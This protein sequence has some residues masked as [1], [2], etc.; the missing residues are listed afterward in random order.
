MEAEK[1]KAKL[2]AGKKKVELE[3]AKKEMERGKHAADEP[4][5]KRKHVAKKGKGERGDELL[6]RKENAQKSDI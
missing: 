6:F 4:P 5:L 2:E 3:A 1:L